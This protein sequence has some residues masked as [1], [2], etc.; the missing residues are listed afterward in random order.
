MVDS[1]DIGVYMP[2]Y[3]NRH[4]NREVV[5]DSDIVLDQAVKDELASGSHMDKSLRMF[6]DV[7]PRIAMGP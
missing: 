7:P 6:T 1:N 3:L 4:F 5:C 2:V